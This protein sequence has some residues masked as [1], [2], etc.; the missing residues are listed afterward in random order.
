MTY[1]LLGKNISYSL[2]PRMH[3]AAFKHFG[4]DAEY[5]LF[6]KKEEEL[7]SFFQNEVLGGQISGFNVTVPYKIKIKELLEEHQG[8]LID[9]DAKLLGA[10]NTV[11]VEEDSLKGFNTDGRGFYESLL[12]DTGLNPK[13]K[14]VL[15]IGAGGAGRAI[16][17]YLASLGEDAPRKINCFD[18]DTK[19]LKSLGA[20]FEN[21]FGSGIFA[22][23]DEGELTV[24]IA[25]SDLVVNATPLGT[26]EGD[27]MPFS[28]DL[29]SES[30]VLYDLV[31]SR[32][33]ELVKK[34]REKGLVA[35]NG[36]GMLINQAALAFNIWT[37]KPVDEVKRV[38][39]EAVRSER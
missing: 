34:T 23:S 36:L 33:T 32:E 37:G 12:E 17:F 6:D 22:S 31:Y 27:T 4:I 30:I 38:M 2:S 11:R 5:K 9:K 10:V 14:E 24:K 26:K 1:G 35:S 13:D 16:C 20:A 21:Q 29:I 25:E 3:N 28:S 18:V 39:T 19:K 8:C 7:D 15:I